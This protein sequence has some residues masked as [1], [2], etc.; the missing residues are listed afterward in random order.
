[1][2]TVC[3]SEF[4]RDGAENRIKSNTSVH[5]V[6]SSNLLIPIEDLLTRMV[7]TA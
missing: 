4:Q 2:R 6:M 5:S 1:M 7:R 3:G